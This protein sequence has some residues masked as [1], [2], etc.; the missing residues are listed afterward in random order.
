MAVRLTAAVPAPRRYADPRRA[1]QRASSRARAGPIA[2]AGWYGEARCQ[3]WLEMEVRIDRQTRGV[4]HAT[5]PPGSGQPARAA[6][7][8][9]A[10][11]QPELFDANGDGV[12]EN[13]SI[14]YGGDSF[15][16][17]D[18]PP[19]GETPKGDPKAHHG[20]GTH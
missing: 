15:A 5:P 2:V 1:G 9:R 6:S 18:P 4:V 13:W 12:I 20:T 7:A 11:S 17:F 3:G 19:S 16:N 8:P 14:A 10:A